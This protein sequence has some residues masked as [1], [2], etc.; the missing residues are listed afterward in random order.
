MEIEHP[1]TLKFI[2]VGNSGVG[3]TCL[4]SRFIRDDFRPEY[5]ATVG[6]AYEQKTISIGGDTYTLQ[7]W[8]TAGQ[9]LYHAITRKYYRDADC[10]IVVYDIVN[11]QSFETVEGWIRDV[12]SNAPTHCKIALVGN[13]LDC[14]AKREVTSGEGRCLAKEHNLMF[15]ETSAATGQNV[16]DMFEEAADQARRAASVSGP[17]GLKLESMIPGKDKKARKK[18]CCK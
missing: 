14:E 10:A 4:I 17:S 8:D 6:V 12:K 13:K 3:K 2:L 1:S 7:I 5:V 11:Q 15:W 18:R 16:R 9:E